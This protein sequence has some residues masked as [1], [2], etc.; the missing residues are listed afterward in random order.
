M[1]GGLDHGAGQPGAV[2]AVAAA[3]SGHVG[4]PARH[5]GSGEELTWNPEAVIGTASSVKVAIYAEVM[6]QARLGAMD[7]AA[8]V[9]TRAMTWPEARAC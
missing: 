3:C 1:A 7:L 6:R 2:A 4:L 9:T 8:T 5:L